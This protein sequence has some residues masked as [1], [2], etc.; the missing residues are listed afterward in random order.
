MSDLAVTARPPRSRSAERVAQAGL[1]G[2]VLYV[3][4]VLAVDDSI[5]G[6]RL[7]PALV[8]MLV[9][10]GVI[11][12]QAGLRLLSRRG[13]VAP[14]TLL[15]VGLLS[16]ALAL[17]LVALDIGVSAYLG[18]KAT[19]IDLARQADRDSASLV[20]EL[21]PRTF[22]PTAENF[23]VHKP[24]V[25][26]TGSHYGGFYLPAMLGSATLR[27]SVLERRSVT[28]RING[29]GFRDSSDIRSCEIFA[30]GDS[31]TFGWG[32][33]EGG[34][35]PDVLERKLGTCVYNLGVN[36]A[37]P[38]EELLLLADRLSRPGQ[39]APRRVLWMLYEGNDLEGTF[40]REAPVMRSKALGRATHGTVLASM[41]SFV[42][43][44]RAQSVVDRLRSGRLQVMSPARRRAR[45]AHYTIDGVPLVTPLFRSARFGPM[46]VDA[47]L[48]DRV[49]RPESYT[50]DHRHRRPLEATL[51]RMA[52][53]RDSHGL[54]VTVVLVPTSAR[55]YAPWFDL[56]PA[57]TREPH[58]LDYLAREA[59]ARR[60]D[61]VNL[62]AAL[63]PWAER[64]LLY[65]RDDDHF[66]PRGHE[67]VAEILAGSLA[68]PA[69]ATGP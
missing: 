62:L 54:A 49:A 30:L 22:Y 60:F 56:D 2:L 21:Y 65:F 16:G 38:H 19:D 12:L 5:A 36:G 9:V 52:S 55:L 53:L 29:I 31:F 37:S 51:D 4:V 26:V 68:P 43:N 45:A 27:D 39:R 1:T 35:W 14:G 11:A 28:I 63:G 13:L 44:L 10:F 57:P 61:V 17:S 42:R 20:G 50:L 25:S 41:G 46:L 23:R 7:T 66:N 15:G 24:G 48:L 8:V 64:E 6:V 59:E 69:G 47:A 33:T 3:L 18:V 32:V 40:A 34:A 67:V 58:L